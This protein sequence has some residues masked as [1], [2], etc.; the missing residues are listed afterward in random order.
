MVAIVQDFRLPEIIEESFPDV[1]EGAS[2]GE[3]DSGHWSND[4]A[5]PF[6]GLTNEEFFHEQQQASEATVGG[7]G[8]F[9]YE[10]ALAEETQISFRIPT[11]PPLPPEDY[12]MTK[13]PPLPLNNSIPLPPPPP[14]PR[15]VSGM[16]YPEVDPNFDINDINLCIICLDPNVSE[17]EEYWDEWDWSPQIRY[18]SSHKRLPCCYR[19][20]CPDCLKAIVRSNIDEG[21]VAISCPHLEC[22]KP[23]K[24]NYI[25]EQCDS[26]T[27][28]KYNRFI[29]DVEN[30]GKKK[31]CPNCCEI[32]EHSLPGFKK[33]KESDLKVTCITCQHQWCFRCHAP[34]HEGL[35][36]KAFQKGNKQFHRWT[37]GRTAGTAN[38]QKCPTCLVYIQK[39]TGCNHMTCNRCE[40]EFC[41]NCG[42]RYIDLGIIDHDSHLNVW[43]CSNNY[44]PDNP[45]L[46]KLVRGG[47]LTAKLTYLA[48]IPV[49]FVGACALVVVG[50][51]IF[52]PIYGGVKLYHFAKYKHSISHNRRRH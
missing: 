39:S 27:K 24:K 37:K 21:K 50:G 12:R 30:D 46:R 49:V 32:T 28:E 19:L 10:L 25:L 5:M 4:Y 36:C 40:T 48:G 38:C 44:H 33:P 2:T 20:I 7:G 26:Q 41:Y 35:T 16:F 42:G 23:F 18:M 6:E 9:V 13:R 22:G 45:V 11:P 52:L 15:P 14:P 34:W 8:Y 29:V 17:Q 31:T 1:K 3:R 43:G 47:Y 51:A